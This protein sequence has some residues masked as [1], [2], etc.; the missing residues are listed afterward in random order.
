[1]MLLL[2]VLKVQVSKMTMQRFLHKLRPLTRPASCISGSEVQKAANGESASD[3][4]GSGGN[5]EAELSS[6]WC[7]V[8]QKM[9]DSLLPPF[10]H[11][12]FAT[13]HKKW[14]SP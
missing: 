7:P 6:E 2:V 11:H 9:K 8:Y 10:P 12:K 5:P 4:G 3:A 1:M 13:Q 14:R